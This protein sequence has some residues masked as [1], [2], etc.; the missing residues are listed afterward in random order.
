[1]ALRARSVGPSLAELPPD[2]LVRVE[3]VAHS[4]CASPRTVWRAGIPFVEITPRVKRFRVRDVR[5]WIEAHVRG[6]A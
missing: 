1:M 6:V 3:D 5:A 2:A 4:L